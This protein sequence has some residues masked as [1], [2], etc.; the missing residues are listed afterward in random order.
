[1]LGSPL[2][3]FDKQIIIEKK[4][5]ATILNDYKKHTRLMGNDLAKSAQM[6]QAAPMNLTFDKLKEQ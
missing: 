6:V 3:E 4:Y 5:G 1:V 2:S